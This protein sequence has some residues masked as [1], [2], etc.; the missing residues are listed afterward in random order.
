MTSSWLDTC[1][2]FGALATVSGQAGVP[3]S[4]EARSKVQGNWH[5]GT[6][7][8][9]YSAPQLEHT[10]ASLSL[11]LQR[12]TALPAHPQTATQKAAQSTTSRPP[13][14][15]HLS[16]NASRRPFTA[17]CDATSAPLAPRGTH[18]PCP[19]PSGASTKQVL[20]H[21]PHP[22]SRCRSSRRVAHGS[23]PPQHHQRRRQKGV[24]ARGSRQH[25]ATAPSE[26]AAEGSA[27]AWLT[28]TCRHS[29]I[30]GGG[31]SERHQRTRVLY[32]PHER[33]LWYTKWYLTTLC[34]LQSLHWI[35]CVLS[36]SS[37]GIVSDSS[38]RSSIW[39]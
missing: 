6:K 33:H 9:Q 15:A 25:A 36:R 11:R 37:A 39:K 31:R 23:M 14:N 7:S 30:R 2:H 26:D 32:E 8:A 38:S 1:L 13:Y 24:P 17:A 20:S 18:A 34:A 22:A 29:T 21:P 10:P 19:H 27:G 4:L 12:E 35:S 5:F 3:A 28:A 16:Q